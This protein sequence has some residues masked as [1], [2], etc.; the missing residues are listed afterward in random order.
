MTSVEKLLSHHSVKTQVKKL[1]RSYSL[2]KT[3]SRAAR[4][5]FLQ[6]SLKDV[7]AFLWIHKIQM[8]MAITQTIPKEDKTPGPL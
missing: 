7:K 8:M 1:T 6:V 3:L 2:I 4:I 5:R